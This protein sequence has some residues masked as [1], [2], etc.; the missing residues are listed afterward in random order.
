MGRRV[1]ITLYDNE[2]LGGCVGE[3]VGIGMYAVEVRLLI[4]LLDSPITH[5]GEEH[6]AVLVPENNLEAE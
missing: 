4:I 3:V 5:N 2:L 6:R 1:R